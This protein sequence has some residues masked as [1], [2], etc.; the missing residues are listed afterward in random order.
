MG[1]SMHCTHINRVYK[2]EFLV[3]DTSHT[4]KC[5]PCVVC[6][7]TVLVY[8]V[9]TQHN[10]FALEA[11]F[12]GIVWVCQKKSNQINPLLGIPILDCGTE[13]ALL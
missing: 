4:N 6:N 1:M 13:A 12:F 9:G 10:L 8:W 5:T 2:K 3:I 11:D 7:D